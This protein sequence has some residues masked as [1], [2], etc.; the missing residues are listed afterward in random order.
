MEDVFTN[1]RFFLNKVL[2]SAEVSSK[3]S[4]SVGGNVGIR[5]TEMGPTLMGGA[6]CWIDWRAVS[7]VGLVISLEEVSVGATSVDD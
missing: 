5:M 7:L 1:L 2:L 3:A 6:D 4:F